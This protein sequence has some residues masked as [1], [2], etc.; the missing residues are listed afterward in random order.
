[1]LFIFKQVRGKVQR[2]ALLPHNSAYSKWSI[3]NFA[4][5][6]EDSPKKE[7]PAQGVLS[8]QRIKSFKLFYLW[9]PLRKTLTELNT[10]LWLALRPEI[11]CT[12][13]KKGKKYQINLFYSN[14]FHFSNS[15]KFILKKNSDITFCR[16]SM[17][18]VSESGQSMSSDQEPLEI[19][20]RKEPLSKLQVFLL[21][22][23]W[24]GLYVMFLDLSVV[25]T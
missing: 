16:E 17:S 20:E 7:D 3:T 10:T 4:K 11:S 21:N 8:V 22:L 19:E 13:K 2:M 14:R 12:P 18:P 25:G 5:H 24:F 23:T 1:M 9:V 6:Q 15:L